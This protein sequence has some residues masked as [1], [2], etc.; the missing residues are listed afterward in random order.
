MPPLA[1][2]VSRCIDDDESL[3]A[4][5]GARLIDGRGGERLADEQG[6]HLGVGRPLGRVGC[7]VRR[8]RVLRRRKLRHQRV[9][10]VTAARSDSGGVSSR[11]YR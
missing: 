11:T 4:L 1:S 5:V 6:P 7:D 9:V 10:D 8:H 2:L 3:I